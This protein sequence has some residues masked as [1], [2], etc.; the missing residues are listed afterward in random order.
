[1]LLRYRNY[2]IILFWKA[3]K[4]GI[5]IF[6]ISAIAY[7]KRGLLGSFTGRALRQPSFE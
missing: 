1:M 7:L 3:K 4:V 2:R 5:S 6:I